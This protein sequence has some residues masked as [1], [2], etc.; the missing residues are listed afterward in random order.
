MVAV[1][2]FIVEPKKLNPKHE[3]FYIV[4]H[5]YH[6]TVPLFI[7]TISRIFLDDHK[8]WKFNIIEQLIIAKRLFMLNVILALKSVKGA[9]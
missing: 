6:L 9:V 4:V 1:S 5:N 2:L 3:L 8:V 7:N